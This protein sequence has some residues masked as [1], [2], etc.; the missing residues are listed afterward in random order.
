LQASRIGPIPD[1]IGPRHLASF[2][3]IG[4]RTTEQKMTADEAN[5]VTGRFRAG[6]VST[7]PLRGVGFEALFE[8]HPRIELVTGPLQEILR[9]HSLHLVLLS[10]PATEALFELIETFKGFRPDIRLIVMCHQTEPDFIRRVISTGAK[11]LLQDSATEQEITMALEM[12]ADGSI[13]AP[14]RVLSSL[15]DSALPKMPTSPANISLTTRE[16]EVLERLVGG[17]T[18]RQISE[19]LKI[20]ERTVKAHIAKLMRKVGVNNRTALT[21][22]AINHQLV[23]TDSDSDAGS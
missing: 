8:N 10:M 7:D 16:R 15:L 23:R 6:L 4:K 22:H 1:V 17:S 2:R 3:E 14:R 19:S 11:G 20:E 18:N 5:P 12:V 9:D 13:W 21:M